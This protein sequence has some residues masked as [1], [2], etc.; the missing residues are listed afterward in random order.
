MAGR[1][2]AAIEVKGGPELRRSLSKLE[3]DAGDLKAVNREAAQDVE[4]EAESL[5]PVR[6]GRLRST[7]KSRASKKAASVVAGG[8]RAV[9]APPIHFGWHRRNIEPHPF[10]YEALDDRR[11]EVI[12]RY[13]DRVDALIRRLDREAP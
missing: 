12:A 5:V 13:N 8:A 11:E 6:S 4:R 10:M 2:G 7:I 9:Y 3:K 1:A